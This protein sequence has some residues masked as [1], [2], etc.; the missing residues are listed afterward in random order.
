MT[1]F[2]PPIK[3]RKEESDFSMSVQEAIK[4]LNSYGKFHANWDKNGAC[5]ANIN[6]IH[7]AI[8]YLIN[9]NDDPY[10]VGMT[11]T[12]RAWIEYLKTNKIDSDYIV[13]D[14]MGMSQHSIIERKTSVSV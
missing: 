4:K 6:S 8:L 7:N 13:F 12:G 10:L 3:R 9:T 1:R 5:E 2:R 14:E 11:P